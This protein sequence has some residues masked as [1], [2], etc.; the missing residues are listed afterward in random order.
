MA[1]R[2]QSVHVSC[3]F[4]LIELVSVLYSRFLKFN[5][6]DPRDPARDY[7]VLSKGHGVMALYACFRQIGWLPQK[8]LDEYFSEGSHLRGLSEADIPGLEVT[9]GSLGH[10][11]PIATGMA[12]G[13]K[14][15]NDPRK[16]VCIVGDGEM[17]EGSMWEA[18]LFA[19][20]HRLDNLL[21]IVDGNQ[22]QAMGKTESILS[23]EPLPKKFESFGFEAAE[24]DGHHVPELERTLET[25]FQ[26]KGKPKA[27]V[28]RTIKG[29]GITFMEGDNKWHYTRISEET[30][31][32]C[33]KELN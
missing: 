2:G 23:L 25:L 17:N 6:A 18:L 9:S 15:R 5:P 31:G 22:F 20:H 1:H 27:L 13:L 21:V 4:S 32:L 8:A 30:L 14:L 26:L 11:L 29:K 19:G 16:V 12:Y 28:A 7:L 3:A 24:C 33:L 10:G